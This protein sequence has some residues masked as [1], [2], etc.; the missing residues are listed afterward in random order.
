LDSDQ[1]YK[2]DVRHKPL[3]LTKNALSNQGSI[4]TPQG[5]TL[6]DDEA[7]PLEKD[8]PLDGARS[9]QGGFPKSKHDIM[10]S[11]E[12]SDARIGAGEPGKIR[13]LRNGSCAL[14]IKRELKLEQQRK[15]EN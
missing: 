9:A 14:R 3:T 4:E 11:H 6:L 5:G 10:G 2:P 1:R 8:H 15:G 12:K 7:G 13:R